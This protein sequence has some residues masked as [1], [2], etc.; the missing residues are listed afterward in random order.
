MQIGQICRDVG[1]GTDKS[2]CTAVVASGNWGQQGGLGCGGVE[3]EVEAE[4]VGCVAGG[5]AGYEAEGVIA[6]CQRFAADGFELGAAEGE[7]VAATEEGG[8]VG[9]FAGGGVV[10]SGAEGGY[11]AV[12]KGDRTADRRI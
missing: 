1:C 2:D 10:E 5:V 11:A 4:G 9:E 6:I 7:T 3:G 12:V 8:D